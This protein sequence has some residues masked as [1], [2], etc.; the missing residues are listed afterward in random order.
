MSTRTS[1][2]SISPPTAAPPPTWLGRRWTTTVAGTPVTVSGKKYRTV[3][4]TCWDLA[5]RK[6]DMQE[7]GVARQVLSPMAE[8]LSYWLPPDAA[9]QLVRHLND[10]IAE[11]VHADEA[12][13]GLG[14]VPL[15]DP[16]AA[17]D[18][19]R[20]VMRE[21]R[22]QAVEVA[23]HVNGVS[24]GDSRFEAFFR[25]AAALGAAVFVHGLRPAGTERLVGPEALAQ[26]VAFPGDVAL[27]AASLV[28]G[29][30]LERHPDL[31]VGLSH[32]GGAFPVVVPRLRRGWETIA[33]IREAMPTDPALTARR[34]W[35]DHLTYDHDSLQLALHT[36]GADK[37][38]IGT[39]Y[40]FAVCDRQS[41][42]AIEQLQLT[43]QIAFNLREENARVFLGLPSS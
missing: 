24:I 43:D 15:Q 5:R 17:I 32:G 20:Y 21:M 23:T 7:M 8:L 41:H 4:S 39:D 3:G 13:L 38:M 11:M 37:V 22:L 35:C 10:A 14:A 29:G 33:P 28:T 27:A 36:F 1:S 18:E 34:F 42:A 40:P 6:V 30:M 12:F 2:R 19:L 31:R 26:M 25:E 16:D 9:Q